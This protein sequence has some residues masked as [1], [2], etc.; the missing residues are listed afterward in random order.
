MPVQIEQVVDCGMAFQKSLRLLDRFEPTH[1]SF[2]H[3]RGL[4]SLNFIAH[5]L[6]TRCV[7]A[8]TTWSSDR[9]ARPTH[10]SQRSAK[11]AWSELMSLRYIRCGSPAPNLSTIAP[12][13]RPI[14]PD[15]IQAIIRKPVSIS[16][17]PK[18]HFLY[19]FFHG[20]NLNPPQTMYW[21]ICQ[22]PFSG[23]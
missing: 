23:T 11:A 21:R 3:T 15:T 1:T 12:S 5:R 16:T 4:A 7:R 9:W 8:S 10:P 18:K 14:T 17:S 20:M 19:D 22:E 13:T 2:P 6:G